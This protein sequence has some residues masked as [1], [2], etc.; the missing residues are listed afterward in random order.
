MNLAGGRNADSSPAS[1]LH[2]IKLSIRNP[3]FFATSRS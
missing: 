2:A 3:N 1:V